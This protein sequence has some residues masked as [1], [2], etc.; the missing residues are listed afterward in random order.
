MF[1]SVVLG[2]IVN[3]DPLLLNLLQIK[4]Q[5]KKTLKVPEV[6]LIDNGDISLS[7]QLF[8]LGYPPFISEEVIF[9]YDFSIR[10]QEIPSRLNFMN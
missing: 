10:V 5:K 3:R 9:M 7:L 4:G 8:S 1:S 2:I 6:L